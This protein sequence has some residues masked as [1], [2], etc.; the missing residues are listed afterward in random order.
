MS[1]TAEQILRLGAP[2]GAQ[3]EARGPAFRERYAVEKAALLAEGRIGCDSLAVERATAAVAAEW[4]G[5]A[6]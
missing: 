1:P 2:L 6:W 4:E 3:R 5:A